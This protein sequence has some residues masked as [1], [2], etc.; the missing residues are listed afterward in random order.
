MIYKQDGLPRIAKVGDVWECPKGMFRRVLSKGRSWENDI[1]GRRHPDENP[2]HFETQE[3]SDGRQAK[4]QQPQA[5]VPT[6]SDQP[7]Q[8]PGNDGDDPEHAAKGGTE[9]PEEIAL[10]E[11]NG[12]LPDAELSNEVKLTE[13]D[14]V[15]LDQAS[16]P[17]PK[18][19]ET[20][21]VD[22]NGS[23]VV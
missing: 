1:P 4:Q 14:G 20:G 18:A 6:G 17:A 2:A 19:P 13:P 10:P 3:T 9:N 11:K 16:K 12:P 21:G 23:P 5:D 7:A 15:H 8:K 22:G